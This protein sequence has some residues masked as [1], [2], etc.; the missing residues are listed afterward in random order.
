MVSERTSPTKPAAPEA[1]RVCK[2]PPDPLPDDPP[3]PVPAEIPPEGAE[4]PPARFSAF[5]CW[6][7]RPL[8]AR[9]AAFASLVTLF[10]SEVRF[11]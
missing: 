2:M 10:S 3:L 1:P 6:S 11:A 8:S 5:A 4:E 9:L 7:R